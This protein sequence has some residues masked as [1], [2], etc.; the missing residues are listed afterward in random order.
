[1]RQ[2][3]ARIVLRRATRVRVVGERVRESLSRITRAPITVLPIFTDLSRYENLPRTKHPRF[4][5]ALLCIGRFEKEKRFDRAIDALAVVRKHGHDAGLT[6]VGSGSGEDMLRNYAREQGVETHCVFAK[7]T[8]D[9]RPHLSEADALLVTSEY[10]GYGMVIVEALAGG[11]PVIARDVG[12]AREAGALVVQGDFAHGV[13]SWVEKGS[14]TGTLSL[15]LPRS[16]DEY[17]V[18]WVND[19]TA[20][21]TS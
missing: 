1:M 3:L 4:K 16:F 6:L 15:Q 19:V 8:D 11:V 21:V 20:C 9:I 12:V 7:W 13:L 18:A 17:V 10:E 5:I 2:M 14:R